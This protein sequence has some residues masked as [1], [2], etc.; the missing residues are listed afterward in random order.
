MYRVE[1]VRGGRVE[2]DTR[3]KDNGVAGYCD[4]AG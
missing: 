2:G 3:T 1:D 4:V